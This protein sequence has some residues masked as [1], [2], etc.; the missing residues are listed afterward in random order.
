MAR[1]QWVLSWGSI[2]RATILNSIS[3]PLSLVSFD[4]VARWLTVN[5]ASIQVS[6]WGIGRWRRS[7]GSLI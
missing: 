4:P 1:S 5:C 7:I 3:S 2:R 6:A